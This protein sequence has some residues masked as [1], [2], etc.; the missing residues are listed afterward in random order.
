MRV[1]LTGAQNQEPAEL[2]SSYVPQPRA[3]IQQNLLLYPTSAYF[4]YPFSFLLRLW[5]YP[6]PTSAMSYRAD[7][8]DR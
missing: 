8:K 1:G 6:W 7:A 4:G 3:R 5:A 2:L